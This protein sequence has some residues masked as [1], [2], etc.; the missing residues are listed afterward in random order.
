MK[1]IDKIKLIF[2]RNW[3]FPGQD[4]ISRLLTPSEDLKRSYKDGI[5]WLSEEKIAI[6]TTADNYI[7]WS[8]L[9][10]GTYENEIGK[11]ISISLKE[12]DVALDIGGNIGLQSLRMAKYVGKTGNV[13]AFEPL[14]HLRKKFARNIL[15]NRFENICLL[16]YA[17][18]DQESLMTFTVNKDQWNQ[19]TF[20]LSQNDVGNITE[21]ISVKIGDQTIEI[22][23]LN[24]LNLIKI[25]VEGFEFNVLSGLTA[26]LKKFKPR[27]IFEYDENYWAVNHQHIL[28][29]Y[30]FLRSLNYTIYQVNAMG[31]E[32]I[33]DPALI[34]GGNLF[35]LQD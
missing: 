6:F 12:G 13:L 30:Q 21:Q 5:T 8:I 3:K 7:E 10:T 18:S 20:S 22:S 19:G 27:L 32:L 23:N 2:S 14:A 16:P 11:L 26:T 25:D 33:S 29:C 4:R 35:C 31:C 28:S 24:K 9:C 17:L 15:L 34:K 1:R